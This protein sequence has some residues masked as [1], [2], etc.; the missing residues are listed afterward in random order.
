MEEDYLRPVDRPHSLKEITDFLT[1]EKPT[2]FEPGRPIPGLKEIVMKGPVLKL[3]LVDLSP[4]FS[5][6]LILSQM[7]D[8][9]LWERRFDLPNLSWR[10]SERKD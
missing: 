10:G 8:G 6:E 9:H 7:L 1:R 2:Q 5:E 4:S 3:H